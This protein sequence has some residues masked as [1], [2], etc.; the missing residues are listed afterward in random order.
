MARVEPTVE[1]RAIW[2][3]SRPVATGYVERLKSGSFRANVFVGRDPIT[4]KRQWL[5]ETHSTEEQARKA[6]ERLVAQVEAEKVPDKA[7]T[8]EYLFDKWMEVADH[9]ADA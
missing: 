8:V 6:Q 7:A 3:Y 5:R 4:G 9:E 2:P 1:P